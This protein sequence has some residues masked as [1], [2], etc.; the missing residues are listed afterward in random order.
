MALLVNLHQ[1]PVVLRMSQPASIDDHNRISSLFRDPFAGFT[2]TGARLALERHCLTTNTTTD[3]LEPSRFD[4]LVP[5]LP[6]KKNRRVKIAEDAER[7]T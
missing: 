7:K 4:Q 5:V 6:Y 2:Y 3:H 1:F